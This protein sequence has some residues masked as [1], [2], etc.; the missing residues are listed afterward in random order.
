MTAPNYLQTPKLKIKEVEEYLK[1]DLPYRVLS[2][3]SDISDLVTNADY[4]VG[5]GDQLRPNHSAIGTV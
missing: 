4:H 2:P 3:Q 5:H 1:L